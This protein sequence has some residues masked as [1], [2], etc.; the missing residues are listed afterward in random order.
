MTCCIQLRTGFWKLACS[1]NEA[2]DYTVFLVCLTSNILG[3]YK[4]KVYRHWPR[5]GRHC[6]TLTRQKKT[7]VRSFIGLCSYNR[8]FIPNFARIAQPLHGGI[9]LFKWTD[10][11]SFK[12]LKDRLTSV[13]ILTHPD[14]TIPFI[15][16]TDAS[17]WALGA[18][19]SQLQD[20]RERV[21]VYA[22]K[23][24]CKSKRSACVKK[25]LLAF[26]TFSKHLRHF[27]YGHKF[28]TRTDPS[29]LKWLLWFKDPEGLLDRWLEV[30]ST[31]DM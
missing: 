17:Q 30:T 26:V 10:K 25:G 24:F 6:K 28:L 27:L 12:L 13:P 9:C 7:E 23:D 15:L 14:F 16:D 8:T 29:S 31:Y 21:V 11:D 18:I 20:G 5:E 19:I 4:K 1:W 3:T 2:E 22:S